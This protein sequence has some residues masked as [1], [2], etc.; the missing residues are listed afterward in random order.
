MKNLL[1]GTVAIILL[2]NSCKK[3]D[4]VTPKEIADSKKF[5][6]NFR[7]S[8]FK[9]SVEGFSKLSATPTTAATP[10]DSSSIAGIYY[11][12][13]NSEGEELYRKIQASD[14]Y[15]A[16]YA[17]DADPEFVD[18]EFGNIQDSL[19]AGTYTII[20]LASPANT[21]AIKLLPT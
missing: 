18:G 3:E 9:L 11:L 19:P 12:V 2:F 21:L 7:V 14:G 20:L 10:A 5:A 1:L 4:A 17:P 13:Y 15:T 6:V 16:K 8:G